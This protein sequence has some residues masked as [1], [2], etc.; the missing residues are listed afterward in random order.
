MAADQLHRHHGIA[1]LHNCVRLL[2]SWGIL[3]LRWFMPH[4]WGIVAFV[5]A[6]YHNSTVCSLG[7]CNLWCKAIASLSQRV[8]TQT[9]CSSR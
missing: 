8:C 4:R 9:E 7:E 6:Y 1:K 2:V 3:M 5:A